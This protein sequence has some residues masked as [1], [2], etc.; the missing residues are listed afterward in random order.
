MRVLITDVSSYKA[1]VIARFLRTS[2][3]SVELIATDHRPFVRSI[4]TRWVQDVRI[5]PAG[6]SDPEAYVEALAALVA[7]HGIDLLIPIN[8]KEIRLLMAAR[9]RFGRALA[10]VGSP[11]LYAALDDKLAFGALL[12]RIGAPAPRLHDTLNAPL[13]LVVKPARGSSAAGVFYLRSEADRQAMREQ[14]GTAP[15]DCVIQDYFEGEGVGFSGYFEEGRILVGYAHRRVSEYP[16]TGGSSVVRER[17]PYDDLPALRALVE[18]V[19]VA[20]PWSGFAMFELKRRGP[21]DFGFIECNPRI[22]GSIHQGLVDGA[23]YFEPLLGP[24]EQAPARSSGLRTALLPLTLLA[25]AGYLARG[26]IRA[27]WAVLRTMVSARLDINP[28]TDP[29]GFLAL[30]RRG[31]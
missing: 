2:Y 9:E 24:P 12:R 11:E 25:L 7:D 3:P 5:L 22:W 31:A 15:R 8:S 10:Y 27:A 20:A 1:A 6:P 29:L 16:V 13:P 26:R 19:L 23:N 18:Q 17:Y 30:L 14:M 21:G 4:H 28:L